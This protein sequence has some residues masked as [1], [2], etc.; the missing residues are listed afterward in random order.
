MWRLAD[1]LEVNQT[2]WLMSSS[3]SLEGVVGVFIFTVIRSRGMICLWVVAYIGAIRV[4]RGNLNKETTR[5][6]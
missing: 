6:N 4:L 2:T 5:K 3:Q 1:I